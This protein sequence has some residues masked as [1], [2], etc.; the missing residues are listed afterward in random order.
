MNA[1]KAHKIWIEQSEAAQT[2]KARFGLTAAFDYLVGEKLMSFTSTASRHPDFARELPRFVSEVRRM[3]APDEI[4]TQL[5]Q[6]ERSQNE[7]NV[8]VLEEDDLLPESPAAV[9]E[10]VQQFMRVKEWLTAPMLGTS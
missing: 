2:I 3:F 1:G 10:C 7:R 8:D 5:A 6:I 9:A 4:G